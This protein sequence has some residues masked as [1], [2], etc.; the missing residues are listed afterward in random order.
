MH[1]PHLPQPHHAPHPADRLRRGGFRPV[2]AVA[3]TV[4]AALVL[5]SCGGS[6]SDDGASAT[7]DTAHDMGADKG[8]DKDA[9][10]GAERTSTTTVPLPAGVNRIDVAFV[11]GMIPHHAQAIE[12]SRLAATNGASPAVVALADEII[13]AQ[14]PEIDQ[15][16]GWLTQWG[17]PVPDTSMDMEEQMKAAGGMMMSGMVSSA[18]MERLR[19]A[20]G[21]EFDRLFLEFMIQHHEGAIQMSDQ[22]LD[23]GTD[24][25]VRRLAEQVKAA[26]QPEIQKMDQ[27]LQQAG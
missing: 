27:L 18:D 9:D 14:Q 12:M 15:M 8:A 25:Q 1:L 7:G 24:P 6:D 26:Q 23:G 3:A 13:A 4:L 10:K 2:M 21:V 5:A 19:A 11:Q 20:R 22:L 16:T 17:Q